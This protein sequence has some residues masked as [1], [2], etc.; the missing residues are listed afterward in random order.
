MSPFNIRSRF[1]KAP[2]HQRFTFMPRYY[3][4]DKEELE[5]RIRMSEREMTADKTAEELRQMKIRSSFRRAREKSLNLDPTR[6]IKKSRFRFL[7]ILV[8][9]ISLAAWLIFSE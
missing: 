2:K 1:F 6:E 5:Q 3:D 4:P 9:L 8:A 7:L